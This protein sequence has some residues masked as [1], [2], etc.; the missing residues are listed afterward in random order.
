VVAVALE[1]A[2]AIDAGVDD[3][4]ARAAGARSEPDLEGLRVGLVAAELQVAAGPEPVGD[5][6]AER[7]DSDLARSLPRLEL[8]TDEAER[9]DVADPSRQPGVGPEPPLHYRIV[10]AGREEVVLADRK[11]TRLNSSHVAISYAVFCL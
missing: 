11:S 1:R 8:R 7:Q 6:V 4:E 2:V 9:V 10:D 5:R 3:L